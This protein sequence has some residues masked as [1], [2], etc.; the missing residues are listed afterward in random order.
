MGFKLEADM[1]AP[2]QS[3]LAQ[4]V[5]YVKTEF[6]TPWGYCD[7]VGC[8]LNLR[9]VRKR[10]RL[11]QCKSIGSLEKVDLLWQIPDEDTGE[12]IPL[13][14][15]AA[16]YSPWLDYERV[17]SLVGSLEKKKFV[18]RDRN[19]CIQKR[20]GWF[21]LHKRLIAIELKLTRV[22]E[23]MWQALRHLAYADESYIALPLPLARKVC[24]SLRGQELRAT[25]LGLLGVSKNQT[26]VLIRSTG[27]T[28]KDPVLQAHCVER[29]WIFHIKDS[30]A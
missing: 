16:R 10:V 1:V 2:V 27:T 9:Q 26:R 14:R 15:L 21:P 30:S 6:R 23:S 5:S 8:S 3:W 24:R 22:E 18:I 11:G 19:G 25:G 20:N 4:Q 7:L 29:F 17:A 12:F 28:D 13:G